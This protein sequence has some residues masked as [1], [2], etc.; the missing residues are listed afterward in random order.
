[1]E[2]TDGY[3]IFHESSNEDRGLELVTQKLIAQIKEAEEDFEIE[4]ISNAKIDADSG[5]SGRAVYYGYQCAVL[6]RRE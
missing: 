4:F 5:G 2:M 3:W 1:M 6:K